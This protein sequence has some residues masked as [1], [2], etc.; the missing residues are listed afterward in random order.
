MPVSPSDP[1]S[2]LTPQVQSP[3]TDPPVTVTGT[4]LMAG[5]G[6]WSWEGTVASWSLVEDKSEPGHQPGVG[7]NVPGRFHGQAI[8]WGSILVEESGE[9][10]SGNGSHLP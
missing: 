10:Q 5:Y 7:P 3:I 4:T 1:P 8:R 9:L 2:S 6:I